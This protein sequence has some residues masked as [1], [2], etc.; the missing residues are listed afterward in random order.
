MTSASGALEVHMTKPDTSYADANYATGQRPSVSGFCIQTKPIVRPKEC[1]FVVDKV[2]QS[3]LIAGTVLDVSQVARAEHT[4]PTQYVAQQAY[5]DPTAPEFRWLFARAWPHIQAAA[6]RLGLEEN[7]LTLRECGRL[8]R[9]DLGGHFNWHPDCDGLVGRQLSV[10]VQLSRPAD[11]AG[12]DLL[13]MG[14][15][16][17][18]GCASRAQGAVCVFPARAQHVVVNSSRTR[19]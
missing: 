14:E 17:K 6:Q 7:E 8:V 16:G 1:K 10:V 3:G 19:F 13:I 18:W 2:T 4:D 9:Y 15:E 5:F 12:G 11:Y